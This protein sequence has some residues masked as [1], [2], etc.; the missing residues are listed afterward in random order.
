M[1]FPNFR[2]PREERKIFQRP[3][4]MTIDLRSFEWVHRKK[5]IILRLLAQYMVFYRFF[6]KKI[7]PQHENFEI[8]SNI[9]VI[10]NDICVGFKRDVRQGIPFHLTLGIKD[11]LPLDYIKKLRLLRYKKN[12]HKNLQRM[13]D[14]WII[15]GGGL[16]FKT[17]YAEKRRK[18]SRMLRCREPL[19]FKFFQKIWM[20]KC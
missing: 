9:F 6:T 14:S 15:L 4:N 19:A 2:R 10:F 8:G 7:Q 3:I 12:I 16:P 11:I 18:T 20:I 13:A 5:M 17:L 1:V